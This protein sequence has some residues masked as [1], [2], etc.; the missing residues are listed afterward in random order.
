MR[1]LLDLLVWAAL[2]AVTI[3]ALTLVPQSPKLTAEPDPR[4]KSGPA[5]DDVFRSNGFDPAL[6]IE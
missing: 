4:W 3:G 6:V 2:I 5:V 1:R